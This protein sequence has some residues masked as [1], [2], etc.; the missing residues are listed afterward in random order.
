MSQATKK[1]IYPW[2]VVGLLS[3]VAFLN[4]LDRQ[5]LAT[6]QT[7]IGAD[8]AELQLSQNFGRLMDIDVIGPGRSPVSREEMGLPPRKCLLC[9]HPARYCMRAR[10]HSTEELLI[11]IR[12]MVAEYEKRL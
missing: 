10:N 2:V 3:V 9:N 7:A 1:N 6:M 5:M 12:Q 8:I 11:K 4:Y